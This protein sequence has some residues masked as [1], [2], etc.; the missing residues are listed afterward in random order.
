MQSVSRFRDITKLGFSEHCYHVLMIEWKISEYEE[1][2]RGVVSRWF[3]LKCKKNKAFRKLQYRL[4]TKFDM[5]RA[6]GPDLLGAVTGSDISK[7]IDKIHVSGR[8]TIRV[9][10][11]R[12]PGA[13]EITLVGV[14]VEK[15]KVLIEPGVEKHSQER[16]EALANGNGRRKE[17]VYYS[18]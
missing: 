8:V 9:L 7:H 18:P 17:Y 12:G 10:F 1:D 13:K 4:Q 11:M 16:Q 3:D 6:A 2:G 5:I 15:D 14:S